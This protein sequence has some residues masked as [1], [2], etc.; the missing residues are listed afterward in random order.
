MDKNR[1][2]YH[3][4]CSHYYTTMVHCV[5]VSIG[6]VIIAA[7]VILVVVIIVLILLY[8]KHSNTLKNQVQ[9]PNTVSTIL[10]YSD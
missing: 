4:I 3:F 6:V 2:V 9:L 5:G 8:C 7:A 10:Y 1:S